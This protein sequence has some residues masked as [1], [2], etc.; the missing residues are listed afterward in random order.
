MADDGLR[1]R[2]LRA[3]E[4]IVVED[5][6]LSLLVALDFS[7]TRL[8]FVVVDEEVDVARDSRP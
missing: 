7:V 8:D 1:G 4:R 2:E 6:V 5:S 3:R